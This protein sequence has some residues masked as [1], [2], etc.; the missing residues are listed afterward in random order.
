M[1]MEEYLGSEKLNRLQQESAAEEIYHLAKRV[2]RRLW[3]GRMLRK[4]AG[5]F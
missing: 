5:I 1:T 3:P 4:I 2:R